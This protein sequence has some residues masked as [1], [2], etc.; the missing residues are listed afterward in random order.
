GAETRRMFQ[1]LLSGD[2]PSLGFENRYVRRDGS[3]IWVQVTVSAIGDGQS[4]ADVFASLVTDISD[5]KRTED[6]LRYNAMHDPLTDLPNRDLLMLRLEMALQ[7]IQQQP[8]YTFTV[9]FLDLDRFKFINDT[10]GH[11]VGDQL[12]IETAQR[13]SSLVRPVDLAARLGGDEFVVLLDGLSDWSQVKPQAENL[14][15]A[16]K[17]PMRVAEREISLTAS[18]GIVVGSSTYTKATDLLRDAD[19]AMYRAKEKGRNG[20]A[21][22]QSKYLQQLID[23]LQLEQDLQRAIADNQFVVVYQPVV[24]L[25][26]GAIVGVEAL[27]RWQH[28]QKGLLSPGSFIGVAEATGLIVPLDRWV[29]R[30][31]CAQ[32]AQWQHT[33]PSAQSLRVS[34]NL[35]AKQLAD[36]TLAEVLETLLEETGLPGHSLTLELTESLLVDNSK[37]VLQLMAQLRRLSVKLAIDDFGTGYS[38][39][40]YLHQFPFNALKIDQTFITHMDTGTVNADIVETIVALSDRLHLTT[41]AEGGESAREIQKL[42]QLGCELS[43]GYYFSPPVT[44][45][46]MAQFLKHSAPFLDKIMNEILIVP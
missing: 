41:I 27:V 33:Y 30:T 22:F 6:R 45:D 43:Q 13:L 1:S 16:I 24:E 46:E 25:M 42:R 8:N 12:L 31:A 4:S 28:P 11:L 36:P 7:R 18:I 40:S 15:A 39:L 20:Y 34:V 2:A 44:A 9:L 23:R 3:L 32:V 38:S 17:S 14:L 26:T 5:R 10:L 37:Q 19:I 35:S 21:R 29:L